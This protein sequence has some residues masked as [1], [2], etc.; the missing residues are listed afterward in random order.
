MMLSDIEHFGDQYGIR[1]QFPVS[2]TTSTMIRGVLQR[3][4]IN[5]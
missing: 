1:Q 4:L 3:D 5:N 2:F